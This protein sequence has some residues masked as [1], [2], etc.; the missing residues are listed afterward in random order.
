MN[1][2]NM[3]AK[4]KVKLTE[5]GLQVLRENHRVLYAT[6]GRVLPYTEP[7]VDAEG[8]CSFQFWVL[9]QE[10]GGSIRLGSE[11]PF[12][13]MILVDEPDEVRDN[14]NKL[15]RELD[16]ALNGEDG[17][18]RQASLCDIVSQVCEIA[19]EAGRPILSDRDL[20][21]VGAR[22]GGHIE[23]VQRGPRAT[24]EVTIVTPQLNCPAGIV[25][26]IPEKDAAS[27]CV[28]SGVLVT[29]VP[30]SLRKANG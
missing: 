12:E 1:T 22:F 7:L 29:L 16:V 24:N 8:Y 6:Y 30:L 3:N 19:R 9:F 20:H 2:L 18:A 28:G 5:Y 4:V 27:W 13:T 15:V 17:A 21:R 11:P 10:F 14:Y 23:K 26:R 25:A